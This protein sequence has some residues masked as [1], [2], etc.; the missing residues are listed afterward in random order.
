VERY[1]PEKR[2]VH[3]LH[4]DWMGGKEAVPLH[5]LRLTPK[6]AAPAST[7]ASPALKQALLRCAVLAGGVG[8]AAG[9]L[10]DRLLPMLL[11]FLR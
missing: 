8:L 2:R 4:D 6:T 10:L 3:V 7:K 9:V 11:P 1:D 5:R